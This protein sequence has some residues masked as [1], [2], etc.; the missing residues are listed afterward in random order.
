MAAGSETSSRS[1]IDVRERC[2]ENLHIFPQGNVEGCIVIQ[3]IPRA[4]PV[5]GE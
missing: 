3:Y 1:Q 5:C 2:V 4:E